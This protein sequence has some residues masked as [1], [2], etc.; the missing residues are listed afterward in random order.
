[1]AKLQGSLYQRSFLLK[2][3]LVDLHNMIHRARHSFIKGENACVFNFFRQLKAELDRH[4]PDRVYVVSEGR[5]RHRH[6][7]AGDY[8]ANRPREI[9]ESFSKQKKKIYQLIKLLP[10][11]FAM[12]RDFECDD[13]I[14]YLARNVYQDHKVT[15]LSTDTDFIQLLD[16]PNVNLWNPIKKR[17]IE[18]WPVDYLTYKSLKGDAADNIKGVSGVGDKTAMKLAKDNSAMKD[19]FKK[20][21]EAETQY[22]HSRELIKFANLCEHEDAIIFE[23]YSQDMDTLYSEFKNMN[24][25]SI[26]G[27]SWCKWIDTM[28]KINE[29]R[30]EGNIAVAAS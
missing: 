20:R 12:H 7:L 17:F 21:P 30:Q 27:K 28:E 2:V 6:A 4:E 23:K 18:P 1:M 24:F 9:D 8:K 11:E 10:V 15:I 16:N 26:V 5:P 22:T 3:L 13:V 19:F 14:A 25:K 29:S